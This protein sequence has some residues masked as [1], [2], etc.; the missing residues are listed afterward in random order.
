MS[1]DTGLRTYAKSNKEKY[2]NINKAYTT[3]AAA[4][5]YGP[6]NQKIQCQGHSRLISEGGV[7]VADHVYSR[8]QSGKFFMD[9]EVAL[10]KDFMF[11]GVYLVCLY[12][13]LESLNVSLNV[14]EIFLDVFSE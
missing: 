2:I 3:I 6:K 8:S 10:D 11:L 9:H 1:D 5:F 13:N 12:M 4:L 7:P 14:R